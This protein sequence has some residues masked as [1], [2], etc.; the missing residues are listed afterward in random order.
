[1]TTPTIVERAGDGSRD[2]KQ[3]KTGPDPFTDASQACGRAIEHIDASI[4]AI[5][6]IER[7]LTGAQ[8]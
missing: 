3:R 7:L 4:A 8:P 6:R 1:M 5:E 2:E